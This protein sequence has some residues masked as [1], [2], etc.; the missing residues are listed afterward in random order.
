[1]EELISELRTFFFENFIFDTDTYLDN[2]VS[3]LDQ[4]VIDSTGVM[5]V[6]AWI[7]EEFQITVE[8][9]EIVPGNMGTIDNIA[10]FITDKIRKNGGDDLAA[11]AL[12]RGDAVCSETTP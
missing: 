10:A 7:E 2:S 6:A 5:E 9:E 4:G 11:T 3:L 8:D 1:M 12:A